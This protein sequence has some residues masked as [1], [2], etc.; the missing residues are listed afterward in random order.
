ML[1]RLS[2]AVGRLKG[3]KTMGFS[4]AIAVA[5]ALQSTDWTTIVAPSQVGPTLLAIGVIVAVL[6]AVTNTPVGKK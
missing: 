4:V 2:R 1:S 6:R 5:G 3:W